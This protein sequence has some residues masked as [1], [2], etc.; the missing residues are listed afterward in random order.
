MQREAVKLRG[1]E[2]FLNST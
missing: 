2:P 1:F